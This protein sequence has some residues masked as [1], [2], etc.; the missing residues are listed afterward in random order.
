MSKHKHLARLEQIWTEQPIFFV[1]TCTCSRRREL[2]SPQ[3]HEICREVWRNS[4][5]L[6]G[7]LVGRY[8]LMPDY[9]HF[10]CAP[11]D[12]RH[13][14]KQFVGKWKEWTAKNALRT[15]DVIMPLW[16]EGFFDHVLRSSESYEEKWDYVAANPVRAGLVSMSEEWPF[17]GEMHELRFD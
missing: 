8:V 12:D 13:T 10:F 1:T 4:E 15:R 5:T 2:A 3:M 9:A 16:Q 17:Q 14:L 6:Y 11:R 7:W